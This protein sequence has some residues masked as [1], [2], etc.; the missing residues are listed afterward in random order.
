MEDDQ[1]PMDIFQ[2]EA[3]EVAKAFD[4]LISAIRNSKGLNEKTKQLIYIAMKATLGDHI[5]IKFH[6]PMAKKLGAKKEEVVDV[7]LMTLTVAGIKPV[8][9]VLPEAVKIYENS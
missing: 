9:S 4:G 6:I 8:L 3:P 5:A 7:I 1:N 2:K